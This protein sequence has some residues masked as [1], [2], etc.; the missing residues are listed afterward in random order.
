MLENSSSGA[1]ATWIAEVHAA[2]R[3]D[4]DAFGRLVAAHWET[5]VRLARAI[6]ASDLDAEDQV[7]EAV[8]T[9]W[10]KLGKLRDP[11]KFG[12]WLRSAV[13][14]R[15]LRRARLRR[16]LRL[17]SVPEA[18][19]A[20]L[21][22]ERLD[23]RRYLAALSARQRAVLWLGEVEG[24]DDVEIGRILGIAA[25][26]VRVHRHAARRRLEGLQGVRS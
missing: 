5:C 22:H 7:Q 25:S 12:S 4:P 1:P 8:I 17:D 9:A 10:R 24:L 16:W 2:R 14:R 23:A 26:T 19:G 6:L 20:A 13:A 21:S 15:C 11:E 3:G 18:S